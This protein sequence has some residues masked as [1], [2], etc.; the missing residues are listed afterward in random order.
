MRSCDTFVALPPATA[1][2]CVVFGKNA[3]RPDTEVQEVIY[4]PAT[5]HEPGTKLQVRRQGEML[6]YPPGH[7]IW[8]SRYSGILENGI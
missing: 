1:N 3:D 7:V 6:H 2:G 4:V 8:Y 5:H